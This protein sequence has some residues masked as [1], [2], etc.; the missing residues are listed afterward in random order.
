MIHTLIVTLR[1]DIDEDVI[2]TLCEK[3]DGLHGV[4]KVERLDADKTE[5]AVVETEEPSLA[6]LMDKMLNVMQAYGVRHQVEAAHTG[7]LPQEPSISDTDRAK[8]FLSEYLSDGPKQEAYVWL[9]SAQVEPPL[10]V[11]SILDA[12][13]ELH[14]RNYDFHGL[15]LQAVRGWTLGTE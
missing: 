2:N 4:W 14:I 3:I 11:R 8:Q 6:Q 9:D 7:V 15:G 13:N 1:S 5:P 10:S 12:C